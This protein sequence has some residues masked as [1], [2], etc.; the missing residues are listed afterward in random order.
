MVSASKKRHKVN[1]IGEN[2]QLR[3]VNMIE[4]DTVK[5]IDMV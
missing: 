3:L 5:T 1:D 4:N 2:K